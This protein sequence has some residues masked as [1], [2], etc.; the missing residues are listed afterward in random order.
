[1]TQ[2]GPASTSNLLGHSDQSFMGG[3]MTQ[4]GEYET[5]S[6]Y[7]PELGIDTWWIGILTDVE[8]HA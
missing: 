8:Y 5:G 4:G 2:D 3:R 7:L 1:M 6:G